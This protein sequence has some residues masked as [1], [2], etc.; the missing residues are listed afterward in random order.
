MAV[1]EFAKTVE[2]SFYVLPEAVNRS[3]ECSSV[4]KICTDFLL[5]Y[6]AEPLLQM[7]DFQHDVRLF[8]KSIFL[9]RKSCGF[10]AG[11][12]RDKPE[13]SVIDTSKW[14]SQSMAA[15]M[16][17]WW[18]ISSHIMEPESLAVSGVPVELGRTPTEHSEEW[19]THGCILMRPESEKSNAS[20]HFDGWC[21]VNGL[22]DEDKFHNQ[23][24][25]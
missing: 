25:N 6:H 23:G 15:D 5:F 8:L 3:Q 12:I 10:S 14:R 20:G 2:L 4:Q 13:P 7:K 21:F 17:L 1:G 18:C 24:H 19:V 9:K 11:C 22:T 16:S